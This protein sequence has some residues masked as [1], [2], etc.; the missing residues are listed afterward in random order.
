MTKHNSDLAVPDNPWK[1][2][3][4]PGKAD[5]E[6][7]QVYFSLMGIKW[8]RKKSALQSADT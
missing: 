1:Q 4:P 3:L 5:P 2:G 8:Y 7:Y 6:K